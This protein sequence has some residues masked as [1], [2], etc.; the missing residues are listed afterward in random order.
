M[1]I[2]YDII[3]IVTLK[4]CENLR[5]LQY[6]GYSDNQDISSLEKKRKEMEIV[7]A[8]LVQSCE[9]GSFVAQKEEGYSH[10]GLYRY[11]WS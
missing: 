8:R 6:L 4:T 7:F 9:V 5:Y 10:I 1:F 3:V 11:V 2:V